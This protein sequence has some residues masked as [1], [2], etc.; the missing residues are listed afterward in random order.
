MTLIIKKINSNLYEINGH[1]ATKEE[2]Y[3]GYYLNELQQEDFIEEIVFQPES[4]TLFEG[5]PKKFYTDVQ[6]KTKVSRKYSKR[7]YL[8]NPHIYTPDF[9]V[10]WVDDSFVNVTEFSE[11]NL[12]FPFIGV[13][14]KENYHSYLEVKASFDQ[15]NMTRMF[16]SHIQPVVWEKYNVYVQLIKPLSLF[17]DTFIPKEILEDFYYQKSGKWGKKGDKKYKW[18]YKTLKEYIK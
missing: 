17:K 3:I 9:K 2:A 16:T 10:I 13:W 4:F 7:Q 18:N 12:E 15:N 14:E 11:F 8:I 5:L 6:L 1:K